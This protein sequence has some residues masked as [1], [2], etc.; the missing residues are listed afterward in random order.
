[1]IST[2]MVYSGNIKFPFHFSGGVYDLEIEML[3]QSQ[4]GITAQVQRHLL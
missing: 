3:L 4:D 2:C 1:M